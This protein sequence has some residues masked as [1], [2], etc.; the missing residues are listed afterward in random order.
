MAILLVIIG[1][2]LFDLIIIAH[3]FGHFYTARSFGIRVNEFAL[4]MG[5]K[6]LKIKKGETVFSLRLFPIGGFCAMEGE[7]EESDDP[8]AFGKK[9]AWKRSIVVI[10][11]AVMNIIL[12]F[13]MTIL[14][15][16]QSSKFAST[17]IS[18]FKA[19]AVSSSSGLA[20]GDEII[21]INGS[22]IYTYKDL[23]FDLTIDGKNEFD[24]EVKRGN[25]ILDLK[26][27]NFKTSLNEK[28]KSVI[29][30]D[31]H[32]KAIDKNFATLITQAYLDTISTIKITWIS[33]VGIITGRFSL[34]NM[35][36]PIG[37]T[38]VIGQAT[39]EGLKTSTLA[40]I[41]NIIAIMAMI[42]IN[43]GVVNLLPLPA[44]DGGRLLILL[45]EMITRKKIKS[46]YE[47]LIHAIGFLLLI[48]LM[49]FSAYS[50][51]AR[52]FGWI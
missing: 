50:D 10:A 34:N 42:T 12:G 39:T 23:T 18:D 26:N 36:G 4:G 7:D 15:L 33:L 31:F 38:S 19:D 29:Q 51:V 40:A 20:E 5:P 8:S 11:G 25:E 13:L 41:N 22:K 35:M 27:V 14:L 43:L 49:I 32:L 45:F 17:T 37:I 16:A 3:E 30:L 6:I 1:V 48:I 24:I 2:I 46:K 47:G 28:G 9:A 21:K 52:I 44:L